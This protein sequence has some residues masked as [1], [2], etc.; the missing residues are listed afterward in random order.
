MTFVFSAATPV[1]IV[2][3]LRDTSVAEGKE[4]VLTA[5]LS[6]PDYTVT[7]MKEDYTIPLDDTKYRQEVVG[8]T[9]NLI[10]PKATSDMNCEFTIVVN[11]DTK[12][13][14]KLVVEGKRS[15]PFGDM[16]GPTCGA[17]TCVSTRVSLP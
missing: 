8:V 4:V 14:A 13:T 12:S 7:W 10:I 3:P 17:P 6:K 2:K 15:E 11:E 1:T 5:E 16:P 9:H